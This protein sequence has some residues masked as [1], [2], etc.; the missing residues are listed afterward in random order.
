MGELGY[1]VERQSGSHRRLVANGRPPITFAFHDK[2]T[3]SPR[4]VGVILVQQ[5]G[6]TPEEAREVLKSA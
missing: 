2:S 4:A 3:V 6:L 1:R 5:V